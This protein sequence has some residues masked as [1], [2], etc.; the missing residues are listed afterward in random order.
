MGVKVFTATISNGQALSNAIDL[1]GAALAGIQMSAAW[2]AADITI[3]ASPDGV[4]YYPVWNNTGNIYSAQVDAQRSIGLNIDLLA[5]AVFVKIRSGYPASP[6]NQSADR[7]L[8]LVAR[9]GCSIS[10]SC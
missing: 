8:L 3:D 6:V 4:V 5:G 1:E 2:T 9:S 7:D 10:V